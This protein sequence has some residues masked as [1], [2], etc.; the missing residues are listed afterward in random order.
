[1]LNF[2]VIVA[3]AVFFFMNPVCAMKMLFWTIGITLVIWVTFY[4]M[5]Y[6]H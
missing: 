6:F 3:L 4:M 1:M 2:L 5:G